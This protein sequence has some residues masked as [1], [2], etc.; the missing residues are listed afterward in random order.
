M[1]KPQFLKAFCLAILP[2]AS[3]GFSADPVPASASTFSLALTVSSTANATVAK[4]A[5]GV[6]IKGAALVDSTTY[7]S[8]KN[9]ATITT[10]EQVTKIVASKYT[11]KEFLTDL[12][13]EENPLIT[14]I[15]GWSIQKIQATTNIE[16]DLNITA[17][18]YF[19]VKKGAAPIS[20]GNRISSNSTVKKSGLNQKVVTSSTT[21]TGEEPV[22]TVTPVSTSYSEALKFA[23][24]LT[25]VVK[26]KTFGLAGIY[27]G[28]Q[29]LAFTKAKDEVIL[30]GAGKFT[31]LAGSTNEQAILEG[32]A[33]LTAGIATDVSTYPGFVVVEDVPNP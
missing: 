30:S 27:T 32:S 23:G 24:G 17:P 15:K 20:L 5:S 21:T 3:Q 9:G 14:D 19:L 28:S 33:A 6:P 16:G 12:T 8:T 22:T 2:I 11:V 18:S 10:T 1:N 13:G 26:G 7:T 4:N 29:K 25:L 31:S